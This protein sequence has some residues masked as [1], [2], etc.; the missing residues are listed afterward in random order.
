[1]I[2]RERRPPETPRQEWI[3]TY[4]DVVTLLLTFFVLL[5]A[6]S[7]MDQ[8]YLSRVTLYTQ[9]H[10]A[11]DKHSAAKAQS[12]LRVVQEMLERPWEVVDK[13]QRIKDLLF[14]DDVLP[15]G[16]DRK[17]LNEN[18]AVLARNQGV[19]LVFTDK[20]LFEPGG[21]QLSDAARELLGQ[22]V[23]LLFLSAAPVNVA[24]YA[25]A[26]E[27]TG[28][29]AYALSENRAMGVLEFFLKRSLPPLRFSI[30][31]YGSTKPLDTT[32]DDK[33]RAANRRV[34]IFLKTAQPLGGYLSS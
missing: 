14:P 29:E 19:A 11:L 5:L 7:S 9:E 6:M 3:L 32:G 8:S 4:G 21:A 33:A 16:V 17:T 27:G 13:E 20:L 1:M 10:G 31:A 24:G 22:L 34:E 26:S 23:P 25:D 28:P 2:R 12:R 15:A 18:M 30:S